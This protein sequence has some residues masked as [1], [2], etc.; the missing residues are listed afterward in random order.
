MEVRS[1]GESHLVFEAWLFL[2]NKI[3]PDRIY[4]YWKPIYDIPDNFFEER[5][6]YDSPTFLTT[7]SGVSV[8]TET[9]IFKNPDCEDVI[10]LRQ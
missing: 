9:L 6:I 3:K 2:D 7:A 5:K 8:E 1:E 10:L 4:F